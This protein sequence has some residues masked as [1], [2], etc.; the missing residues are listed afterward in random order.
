MWPV[1]LASV[2]AGTGSLIVFRL[3]LK[4]G[5][6]SEVGNAENRLLRPSYC[7]EV[8]VR[9]MSVAKRKKLGVNRHRRPRPKPHTPF[10]KRAFSIP[11]DTGLPPNGSPFM[12]KMMN[13]DV[14]VG[15][16]APNSAAATQ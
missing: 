11:T 9:G 15:G 8:A 2:T 1:A 16:K 13:H 14:S 3:S 5:P 10:T 12:G 6:T 7:A 4:A